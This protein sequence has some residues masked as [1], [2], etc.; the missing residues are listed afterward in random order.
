MR[1]FC[2]GRTDSPIAPPARP[3]LSRVRAGYAHVF[4]LKRAK[5]RNAAYRGAGPTNAFRSPRDDARHCRQPEQQSRLAGAAKSDCEVRHR[6]GNVEHRMLIYRAPPHPRPIR[7]IDTMPASLEVVPESITVTWPDR[8]P[9]MSSRAA[10]SSPTHTVPPPAMAV[11]A[12]A[13]AHGTQRQRDTPTS[14]FVTSWS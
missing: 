8:H 9:W 10:D 13:A 14:S 2:N 7:R 4:N 12:P 11:T 3:A 6:R 1:K 5:S